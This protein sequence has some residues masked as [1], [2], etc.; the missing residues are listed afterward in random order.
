MKTV[1]CFGDSLTDINAFGYSWTEELATSLPR[2]NVVNSGK[3]GGLTTDFML[4]DKRHVDEEKINRAVLD[5]DPTWVIIELGG[6]DLVTTRDQA[7]EIFNRYKIIVDYLR[8][9][10]I[11]VI[12]GTYGITKEQCDRIWDEEGIHLHSKVMLKIRFSTHDRLITNYNKTWTRRPEP[13]ICM[14]EGITE[15]KKID[16]RFLRDAV[17]LTKDGAENVGAHIADQ[18]ANY[19]Y[20]QLED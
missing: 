9:K 11:R 2:I 14:Y 15:N 5:Y 8:K 18:L 6:N 13:L 12:M 17:H 4:P 20:S 16:S 10:G 7:P 1:V 3:Y 19:F